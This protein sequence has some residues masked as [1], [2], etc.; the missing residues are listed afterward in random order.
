[1]GGRVEKFRNRFGKTRRQVSRAPAGSAK[2]SPGDRAALFLLGHATAHDSAR[3]PADPRHRRPERRAPPAARWPCCCSARPTC[4][5]A[6]SAAT[7]G[8]TPT[9]PPS[10]TCS[11]WRARRHRLAGAH[12]AGPAARIRRPAALLA[13]RLGHPGRAGLGARR[14]RGRASPSSA[15]LVLTLLATW[16]GVYYLARTPRAQP[17]PFA[18]GGEA[19]PTDYARAIADGGLLALIACLGLAQL[20]TRP[21]RR[22]RS[23]ALPPW[24]STAS[25]PCPYRAARAAGRAGGRPGRAGAERRAEPRRVLL[26]VGSAV[27]TPAATRR[28]KA[29]RRA[30]AGSG[31]ALTARRPPSRSPLLAWRARPVALAHRLPAGSARTGSSAAAPAAVVHLAGLA[32]GGL[33]AV[34][35]APPARR[36]PRRPAA[37]VRAG[38]V[39]ATLLTPFVRPLAAA[40]PAGAG[41]AGRLRAAH[42]APQRRGADRLVHAAVLHR[43]RGRHLGDLDLAADRRA[44]QAGGQRGQLAP[45][46]VPSF[47]L[48]AFVAGAGRHRGLGLAGALAH[49]AP[50][51]AL[52]KSLVLPAGGAALCWLLLM[53]LWLPV[54]DY[55]RSYAP[56]VRGI[57]PDRWTS[58]AACE[59]FGLHARPD[60]G[61][62]LPRPAG[63]AARPRRAAS[64]PGWWSAPSARRPPRMASGHERSGA[65]WPPCAARPT[66]RTTCLLYRHRSQRRPAADV[67]AARSS[68]AMRAPCSSG[69]LAAMAFGVTDTIVAGRYAEQA[70]AALS[71]GSAVFISVFVGLHGRAAGAAAGLGRAA[72]RR[73]RHRRSAARCASR[74][75]CALAAMVPGMAG[76][77]VS[78]RRCCAGPRC[79]RA[80]GE[81][82]RLPRRA[83]AGAA[84][85]A[86]VPRC[87]AR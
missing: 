76:P 42:A 2:G 59:V 40:G 28:P 12:A 48:I 41:H 37:V 43:L 33:D 16:Y 46:F 36:A 55:A 34:A 38:A 81:V 77:A 44:G 56:L 87:S 62:A 51:A 83:R 60:R 63:P 1:M 78:R 84:A 73:P 14:L 6:S 86:A 69:Q 19:Q 61:A 79:R 58:P 68:P 27:V 74:S 71:V 39:A 21:R 26:G 20:R 24:P 15:L 52:W 25:P 23:W 64:A 57:A 72:R 3:E 10:A 9:S 82:Q 45:G 4:C 54:L 47:S 18:F 49:R 7:R 85:R 53:T 70:L 22:W 80:A 35:L 30:H 31:R 11:N 65:S 13:R 66:P 17:V 29:A 50:P 67:G 32:A 8:R 5:P 75:T